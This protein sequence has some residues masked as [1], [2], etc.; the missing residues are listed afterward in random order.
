MTEETS[1]QEFDRRGL[2][3]EMR[4]MLDQ[5]TRE[6]V[7]WNPEDMPQ[8]VGT[9][10]DMTPDCDCGGYGPHNILFIDLPN[11]DGVA[12]HVFHTTLRSQIEPKLKQGRLGIGDLI[13]I[14]H[15]GTKASSVKGH[16]DMNMYR[17]VTKP[18]MP[19]VRYSPTG[20]EV[21]YDNR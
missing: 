13:A 14:S 5:S 7:G 1:G 8:F 11:G 21:E 4:A 2:S 3:D 10:A 17:V 6:Y 18:Q 15:L 12:V 16:N 19:K 20:E 9:L